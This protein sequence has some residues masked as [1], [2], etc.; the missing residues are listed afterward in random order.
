MYN[1]KTWIIVME[2]S[3]FLF[4]LVFFLNHFYHFYH[5]TNVPCVSCHIFTPSSRNSQMYRRTDRPRRVPLFKGKN[6][7]RLRRFRVLQHCK[8]VSLSSW[9][10][11]GDLRTRGFAVGQSSPFC[12]V[13]N[14]FF[15]F[16]KTS[17]KLSQW[18]CHMFWDF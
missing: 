6:V 2:H 11:R 4:F 12:P 8:V 18:L 3:G 9:T 16:W 14:F 17:L 15:F 1:K 7:K 13:T 5:L 10:L